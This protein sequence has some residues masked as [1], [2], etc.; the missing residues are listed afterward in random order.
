[1]RIFDG[2]TDPIFGVLLDRTHG[3]LGKFRPW[4]LIGNVI[5]VATVI[6]IFSVSPAGTGSE[7]YLITTVLY[8]IYVLG[9]T[10]QNAVTRAAQASLTNDP[11]QRPLFT[12]FDAIYNALLFNIMTWIITTVLPPAYANLNSQQI[13]A[14]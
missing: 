11:K 12:L 7:K 13:I 2:V 3:K 8:V 14:C 10:M 6:G 9:Y 5:M 4:M 1:M